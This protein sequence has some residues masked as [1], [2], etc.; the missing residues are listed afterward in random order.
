MNAGSDRRGPSRPPLPRLGGDYRL[1]T[2][3]EAP[4]REHPAHHPRPVP[5]RLPVRRGPPAGPDPQPR[6][7]RR[8]RR[9][10]R[11]ALQPGHSLFARPGLPLHGHLPDEQPGGRQRHPAR[12]PLRQRRPRRPA[13]RLHADPVRVHGPGHRSPTGHR[14]RRPPALRLRGGPAR[15]R[16]GARPPRCHVAVDR[17]APGP[18]SRACPTTSRRR[19]P[20]SPNGPPSTASRPSSPIGPSTGSGGRTGTVV[21]APELPA[22]PSALRGGR[23]VGRPLRPRRRRS[24]RSP[25]S[26]HPLPARDR[27]DPRGHRRPHRRGEAAPA[28]GASTSG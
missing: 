25:P 5:G 14:P 24:T 6:R 23:D 10:A 27:P 22:P 20:P 17:L 9:A 18:R 28:P 16:G 13:G 12:R 3:P 4:V 26:P 1:G 7:A 2:R 19:W 8:R 21:R 11:S 15:L